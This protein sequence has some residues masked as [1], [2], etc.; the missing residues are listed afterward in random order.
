MKL[1]ENHIYLKIYHEIIFNNLI[2]E[3]E[4]GT[5]KEEMLIYIII[6]TLF[7]KKTKYSLKFEEIFVKM[8]A[9]VFDS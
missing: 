9:F 8:I 4:I 5:L 3:L 1:S 2:N 6:P 7:P